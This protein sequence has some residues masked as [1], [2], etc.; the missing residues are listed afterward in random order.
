ML[1]DEFAQEGFIVLLATDGE[2][3]VKIALEEHPDLVILDLL[4]PKV[5]GIEVLKQIRAEEWGKEVPVLVLSNIGDTDKVNQAIGLGVSD[6]LVKT[7]W[8]IGDVIMKAKE[9]LNI[10]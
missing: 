7:D 6:Y 9:K 8:K 1:E 2:E 3:G 4:M 10:F 5:D